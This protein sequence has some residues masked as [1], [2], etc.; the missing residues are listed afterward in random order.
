MFSLKNLLLGLAVGRPLLH[1]GR[2]VVGFSPVELSV[3]DQAVVRYGPAPEARTVM[4][5]EIKQPAVFAEVATRAT[6]RLLE[7]FPIRQPPP[8]GQAKRSP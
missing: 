2:E 1:E 5:F 3:D 6:A 4:R 8:A 7:T